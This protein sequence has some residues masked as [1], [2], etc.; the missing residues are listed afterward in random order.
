V[1]QKN[2]CMA[3]R[4][5]Y[6]CVSTSTTLTLY[7]MDSGSVINT[8]KAKRSFGYLAFLSDEI[9]L[10]ECNSEYYIAYHLPDF[11]LISRSKKHEDIWPGCYPLSDGIHYI[12]NYSFVDKTIRIEGMSLNSR[13]TVDSIGEDSAYEIP[14]REKSLP[15]R[16]TKFFYDNCRDYGV[17]VISYLNEG[18]IYENYEWCEFSKSG[19]L[20]KQLLDRT[21]CR[22]YLEGWFWDGDT[23]YYVCSHIPPEVSERK[24]MLY[25]SK[26]DK[27]S[28]IAPILPLFSLFKIDYSLKKKY[29]LLEFLGIYAN[30]TVQVVNYQDLST[31]KKCTFRGA[32]NFRVQEDKIL[33]STIKGSYVIDMDTFMEMEEEL[34]F[35]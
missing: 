11:V 16:I 8:V 32:V 3:I 30:I 28:A 31:I 33:L 13:L 2:C 20:K 27:W 7:D 17:A 25:N 5:N 4:K 15:F 6:L 21:D 10:V 26:E 14:L 12:Y 35:L 24:V 19:L 23:K 18:D 22:A 34:K 1:K 9:I 29:I